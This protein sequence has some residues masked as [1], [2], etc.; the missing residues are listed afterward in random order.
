VILSSGRTLV[1]TEALGF[2]KDPSHAPHD[3]LKHNLHR[4]ERAC[5][6][7]ALEESGGKIKGAENAASSLGLSPS[8]LR[9]RMKKFGI[10]RP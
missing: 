4:V 3:L 7:A 6:I 1:V 5:I 8:S 2:V 9:A 10:T